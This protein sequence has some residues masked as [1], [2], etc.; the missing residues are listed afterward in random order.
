MARL[1]LVVTGF[2]S[3]LYRTLYFAQQVVAAG[4]DVSFLG[5]EEVQEIVTQNGFP[6]RTI[7]D[8][9]INP[10]KGP[11]PRATLKDRLSLAKRRERSEKTIA[12]YNVDDLAGALA[13]TAPDLVIINSEL[14]AHIIT[15][16]AGKYRVALIA[17]MFITAPSLLS[18]PLHFRQV[19]GK[20]AR[21]S[22]YAVAAGWVYYFAKKR[23]MLLR[24]AWR[25]WGSD[26]VS[27]LRHM[28][29][30]NGVKLRTRTNSWPFPWAYR[31]PTLILLP[32]A[33]DLP[34]K[35]WPEIRYVGGRTSVNKNNQNSDISSF[36]DFTS[37]EDGKKRIIV[38]FGSFLKPTSNTVRAIFTA[39]E[40]HPEW[41][42][43][44][45]INETHL[46]MLP[47]VPDNMQVETWAPLDD[48]IPYADVIVTHG[49]NATILEAVN[50][51]VPMLVY[52]IN[53]DQCG[54]SARV[55]FHNLGIAGASTDN[56][57]TIAAH[58][59]TLIEDISI[60]TSLEEMQKE[61]QHEIEN[62]SAVRAVQD[63]L[64][65]QWARL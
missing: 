30:S 15:A 54:G 4:H 41:R 55:S 39:I 10:F 19:P 8:P 5:P 60:Q 27:A 32:S 36:S 52:P 23:L 48:L 63:L 29:R 14:H 13:E 3:S 53:N 20:G 47:P 31:L 40:D 24:S 12:H 17:S 49:G 44:F 45:L 1:T 9:W 16:L 56:A 38:T 34:K 7:P 25:E 46:D 2:R 11:L 26:L 35:N 51:K 61:C 58:I 57:A 50:A 28:A 62:G 37:N 21:G 22:R 65:D 64:D 43:L 42:V 33:L 6:F 59:D 18:P